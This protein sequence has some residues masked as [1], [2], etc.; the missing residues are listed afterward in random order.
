MCCFFFCFVK[1]TPHGYNISLSLRFSLV[2]INPLVQLAQ[3]E[4]KSLQ[5]WKK[6][7]KMFCFKRTD[8]HPSRQTDIR[9]G[10]ACWKQ[11]GSMADGTERLQLK[12]DGQHAFGRSTGRFELKGNMA[13]S[14]LHISSQFST[15]FHRGVLQVWV[16]SSKKTAFV[17]CLSMPLN[18]KLQSSKTM[19]SPPKA[20]L[21]DLQPSHP[22]TTTIMRTLQRYATAKLLANINTWLW[23]RIKRSMSTAEHLWH[24]QLLSRDW[25]R[26]RS[27]FPGGPPLLNSKNEC[28]LLSKAGRPLFLDPWRA[29]AGVMSLNKEARGKFALH[30]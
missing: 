10:A 3:N 2:N 6:N 17:L 1:T 15:H 8:S 27:P 14:L 24:L 9:C 7:S 19:V 16:S 23:A 30:W 12:A 5:F 26:E 20:P 21:S 11:P 22:T 13:S 28:D 25:D 18:T 4:N 29:N